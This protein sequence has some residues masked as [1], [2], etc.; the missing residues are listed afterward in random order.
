M[1]QKREEKQSNHL[2]SRQLVAERLRLTR[3]GVVLL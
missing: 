1:I 3:L 2:Q